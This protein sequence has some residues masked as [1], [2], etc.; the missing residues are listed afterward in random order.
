MEHRGAIGADEVPAGRG[1]AARAPDLVALLVVAIWGASFPIQK[2]ALAEIDWLALTWVRYVGMVALGWLVLLW[3]RARGRPVGVARADLP[4]VVLTGVLGYS[5]YIVLSTAGLAWTTAF[6]TALLVGTAP[7]FA[8]V[9]LAMLGL[10]AMR[11]GHVAGLLV[12]LVGVVVFLAHKMAAALPVAGAGDLLSLAGALSF[13]AYSVAQKP[14]L[15]RYAV[16]VMM[17]HTCALGALPVVALG[18]PAALAQDWT[19]VSTAAWLGLAWTIVIPVYLAWSL[20]AW[21]MARAGVGRTSLFMF[22]VPVAGAIVSHLVVG[23]TFETL[24]IAGALLIVT[25][26]AV[27]RRTPRAGAVGPAERPAALGAQPGRS[28]RPSAV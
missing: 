14:L 17:A 19:R 11:R 8:V 23:E 18:W 28:A 20:W 24:Q 7:L 27:A 25:G 1:A 13:A 10:E 15:E 9:L 21:V 26:L 2:V 16:S 22:L 12:G 5:V 6:S 3:R 4:R